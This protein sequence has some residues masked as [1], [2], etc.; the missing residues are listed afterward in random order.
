MLIM[1]DNLTLPIQ[2]SFQSITLDPGVLGLI[3]FILSVVYYYYRFLY[4]QVETFAIYDQAFKTL[5]VMLIV[6][7]SLAVLNNLDYYVNDWT[8]VFDLTDGRIFYPGL[9]LGSVVSVFF[10]SSKMAAKT[11]FL[12]LLDQAVK[13]YSL[14]VIWL[15]LGVFLSARSFGVVYEGWLAISYTDGAMRFPLHIIQLVYNIAAFVIFL[16]VSKPGNRSGTAAAFYIMVYA[17]LEFILRFFTSSFEPVIFNIIDLHQFIYLILL[18]FSI[19]VLLRI[20]QIQS[21]E[22]AGKLDEIDVKRRNKIDLKD[23]KPSKIPAKELFSLSYSSSE[24][25][26]EGFFLRRN[27]LQD[28]VN[29]NTKSS[30]VKDRSTN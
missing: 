28:L 25:R 29:K 12:N 18:V 6:A 26:N 8:K 21:I 30:A 14:S 16:V 5:F 11:G 27:K 20:N 3:L 15:I 24:S 19:M 7:R 10:F 1:T 17:A 4:K 23:F 22:A 9:L 2:I 13:I